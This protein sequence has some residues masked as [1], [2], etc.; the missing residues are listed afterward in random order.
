MRFLKVILWA[1]LLVALGVFA[2][3]NWNITSIRLFGGLTWDT[4][5]PVPI[6]GA[7]LAGLLPLYLIHRASRWR[8][9]RRIKSLESENAAL[10]GRLTPPPPPMS[11]SPADASPQEGSAL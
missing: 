4:K 2:A 9:L 6:I 3:N 11:E 10:Q 5:L 8:L 1:V 7:F